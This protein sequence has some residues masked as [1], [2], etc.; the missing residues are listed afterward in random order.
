MCDI[1]V[2]K[3]VGYKSTFK[4]LKLSIMAVTNMKKEVKKRFPFT[5]ASNK[6][7]SALQVPVWQAQSPEFKPQSYPL[8]KISLK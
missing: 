1:H 8:R 4:N 2:C 3:V 5:R 6:F 7:I